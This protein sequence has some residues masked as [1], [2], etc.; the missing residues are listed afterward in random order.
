VNQVATRLAQDHYD[1]LGGMGR[2]VAWVK[3]IKKALEHEFPPAQINA[4]L[5]FISDRNWSLTEER[6]ATTLRGGPRPA[7]G[8]PPRAATGRPRPAATRPA[9]A[10]T[11]EQAR[12]RFGRVE[13]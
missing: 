4:A 1:R 5:T 2:V 8:P 13:N 11:P 6:L 3:I 9:G 12:A 10:M 7:G